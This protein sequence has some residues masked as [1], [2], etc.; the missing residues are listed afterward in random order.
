MTTVPVDGFEELSRFCRDQISHIHTIRS[1]VAVT[2]ALIDM[3]P[4]LPYTF[5]DVAAARLARL[6]VIAHAVSIE[7]GVTATAWMISRAIGFLSAARV[8]ATPGGVV[9]AAITDLLAS[10]SAALTESL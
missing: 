9:H 7:H 1:R 2:A 5:D 4:S 10:A 8:L 6:A 3:A